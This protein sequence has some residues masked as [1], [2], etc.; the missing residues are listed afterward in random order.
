MNGSKE[1]ER[2]LQAEATE[3][4]KDEYLN[5]IHYRLRNWRQQIHQTGGATELEE[6][7]D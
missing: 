4:P 2:P 3:M 1:T 7:Y 5:Q 6:K